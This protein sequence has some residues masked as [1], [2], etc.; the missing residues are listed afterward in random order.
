MLSRTGTL[1]TR[2]G[3]CP[4][5]ERAHRRARTNLPVTRPGLARPTSPPSI[6]VSRAWEHLDN[7]AHLHQTLDYATPLEFLTQDLFFSKE[8]KCHHST[9]RVHKP[10]PKGLYRQGSSTVSSCT[11]RLHCARCRLAIRLVGLPAGTTVVRATP[12]GEGRWGEFSCAPPPPARWRTSAKN[13]GVALTTSSP[14]RRG[15]P[16]DAG[17]RRAPPRHG[18]RSRRGESV[19]TRVP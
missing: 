14:S 9:G 1:S 8:A 6:A 5:G 7:T 19:P 15:A 3:G 11:A 2:E 18:C 16:C 10:P 4:G 17:T 13:E 12:S